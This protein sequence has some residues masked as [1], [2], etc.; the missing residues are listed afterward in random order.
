MTE[1]SLLGMLPEDISAFL[2]T[3]QPY[4]GRQIFERIG[5]GTASFD[6]MTDIPLF[7]RDFLQ[8]EAALYTGAVSK[9]V[10]ADD[11]TQKFQIE[12]PDDP[13]ENSV[14]A[15][16]AVI[17]TDETGRKTACVSSQAGCPAGCTFCQTGKLGFKRNLLPSEIVEQFFLL[18]KSADI[19]GKKAPL[20]NLV[21]MGMGEPLL[22]LEAV[23]KAIAVLTHKSGRNLSPRRITVSTSGIISGIYELADTV[24][25]VRLAVSLTTAN[26][27]LR[28]KLMPVARTNPLPE[29]QKAIRYWCEKTGKRCTVEVALFSGINTDQQSMSKLADFCGETGSHV[30]LIP[31]NPVE[32]LLFTRPA[33]AECQKALQFLKQAGINATLRLSRGGTVA[34]ACGQLGVL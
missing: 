23:R 9:K 17:L 34:G 10:I 3:E 15:I 31:W 30:N 11:G 25:E 12:F 27:E 7:L 19:S 22:N 28:K 33:R 5:A 20:D 6:A 4:R 18:E 26:E 14:T 24:P 2:D 16:E 32:G 21:F 29:L 13:S 1:N 8:H